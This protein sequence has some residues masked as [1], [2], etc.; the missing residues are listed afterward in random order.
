[1]P[2]PEITYEPRH[3]GNRQR[4]C[5]RDRARSGGLSRSRERDNKFDKDV[6]GRRADQV[7][8]RQRDRKLARDA[9]RWPAAKPTPL[10]LFTGRAGSRSATCCVLDSTANQVSRPDRPLDCAIT[11]D[12]AHTTTKGGRPLPAR[13][14]QQVARSNCSP[15]RTL[16]PQ[17]SRYRPSARDHG[18][19]RPVPDLRVLRALACWQASCDASTF[20]RA[21]QWPRDPRD[22][23][24]RRPPLINSRQ[25]APLPTAALLRPTSPSSLSSW[26]REKPSDQGV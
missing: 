1:M 9:S 7:D 24:G 8:R 25:C 12:G 3:G 11:C 20:N 17:R 6:R 26:T 21:R 5:Q 16:P 19:Q 13:P 2:S 23:T 10:S 14:A 22:G 18:Q 15:A 4:A